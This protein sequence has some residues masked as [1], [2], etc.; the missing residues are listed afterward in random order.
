[1]KIKV[2]QKHIQRG[3]RFSPYCCP[4]AQAI[5]GSFS[6]WKRLFKSVYVFEH[7]TLIDSKCVK[8]PAEAQAFRE[9]FD[10][11]CS[12]EPFEFELAI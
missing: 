8:L 9:R 6:W 11:G 1:M 3:I 10:R 4:L 5:S 12:V 7:S 2:E